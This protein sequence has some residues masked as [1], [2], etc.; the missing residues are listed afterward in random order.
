MKRLVPFLG[1][2]VLLAGCGSR[3]SP[4]ASALSGTNDTS[5][6]DLAG[7]VVNEKPAAQTTATPVSTVQANGV[8]TPEIHVAVPPPKP[9][10]D[11][12]V[13]AAEVVR[14]SQHVLG[15]SV[16]VDYIN[17]INEPFTLN[18]DQVIYLSDLGM[19]QPVIQALIKRTAVFAPARTV[20]ADST[21]PPIATPSPMDESGATNSIL[22]NYLVSTN[23]GYPAGTPYF[24]APMAMAGAAPQGVPQGVP[25]VQPPPGPQP[26]AELAQPGPMDNA[27]IYTALS[28]YGDWV[29]DPDYGWSWQP[30]VAAVDTGWRPY[31]DS[32]NWVWTDAGWYWNSSYSWGWLPF[33]YGR[34]TLAS[35]RGWI[36]VP[37]SVWG[38]AWVTWRS[39]DTLCGW[40]PL[41]PGAYWRHE[42]L[43]YHGSH[44]GLGF[45]FGLGEGWYCAVPFGSF[46]DPWVYRHRV[47]GPTI[48]IFIGNSRIVNDYRHGGGADRGHFVNHGPGV[49]PVEKATRTEIV[50]YN[51][52]DLPRP[53]GV[54]PLPGRPG[55]PAAG[56]GRTV[57]AYRGDLPT[58]AE[59]PPSSVLA[60]QAD[61][62]VHD[63]PYTTSLA[64][65][66][67]GLQS[68]TTSG[69]TDTGFVRP[70]SS[71]STFGERGA[72]NS[73]TPGFA[74]S[75]TSVP[76]NPPS[77]STA[78]T[79]PTGYSP[80]TGGTVTSTGRPASPGFGASQS[81]GNEPAGR[82]ST[83]GG[84]TAAMNGNP[85]R[86]QSPGVANGVGAPPVPVRSGRSEPA[87]AVSNPD[88]FA[89]GE[90]A[91]SRASATPRP[92]GD[93]ALYSAGLP[94]AGGTPARPSPAG[95]YQQ[96]QYPPAQVARPYSPPPT[97]YNPQQSL[98]AQHQYQYSAP[99]PAPQQH[100]S[101]PPP[102]PAPAPSH[103]GGGGAAQPVHQATGNRKG[104]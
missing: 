78:A 38:P 74:N 84:S 13:P 8:P 61:R 32:G 3:S 81:N 82:S 54:T 35:S 101:A 12:P 5:G 43:Y 68:T 100:Y 103:S 52:N 76:R 99:A 47:S 94:A 28:P 85:G 27:Q 2:V 17:S 26:V 57:A 70:T 60:H 6:I 9:P 20:L 34:W 22:T 58:V 77:P 80:V 41:P 71:A 86:P 96:S 4:L 73:G 42:G 69:R 40:A 1:L 10:P 45:D 89:H 97:Y 11:L 93:P 37:D 24:A 30:T 91:W 65:H 7:P 15:E 29:E 83:I 23:P 87:A 66:P 51:F 92:V 59:R 53:G 46:C 79:R 33:H 39:T 19:P 102:A 67:A 88:V 95:S 72:P 36:W 31:L 55:G 49:A 56:P 50:K 64:P 48:A 14:L 63:T 90:A 104:N 62:Q 75:S 16:L 25:M 98:P 44:V 18:A 21:Q